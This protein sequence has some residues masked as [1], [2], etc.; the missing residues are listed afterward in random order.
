MH[1]K[2]L[3]SLVT[4]GASI[5][6]IGVAKTLLSKNP[7]EDRQTIKIKEALVALGAFMQCNKLSDECLEYV[8]NKLDSIIPMFKYH[9][10]KSISE[11]EIPC[12]YVLRKVVAY[13]G[14]VIYA[15]IKHQEEE[16]KIPNV[17]FYLV[18][19]EKDKTLDA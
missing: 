13:S 11:L 17:L 9:G 6:A 8:D 3:S 12:G 16:G 4:V 7:K 15:L 19:E 2:V 14:K 18:T 1:K 10:T 5:I